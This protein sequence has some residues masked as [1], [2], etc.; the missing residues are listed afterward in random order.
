MHDAGSYG[1]PGAFIRELI[2]VDTAIGRPL[3]AG[4][5]LTVEPG[6]YLRENGLAQLQ[7]TF[8]DRVSEAEINEF[9]DRVSPVYEKYENTGVRIEDDVLIT[10]SGHMVLSSGIPKE[11]G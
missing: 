6:I 2:A 5:V 8:G 11:A 7:E 10:E 1:L 3:A 4:M 9:I